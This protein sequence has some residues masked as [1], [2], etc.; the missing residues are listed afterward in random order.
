MTLTDDVLDKIGGVQRN[1]LSAVLEPDH[2]LT[3]TEEPVVFHP[4]PYTDHDSLVNVLKNKNDVFKCLSVNIQSINSKIDQL[5]IYLNQLQIDNC[6]FDAICIQET[7]LTGGSSTDHLQIEGYTMINSPCSLTSHSGLAIYLKYNIDYERI[8][9]APSQSQSWEGQFIHVKFPGNKDL[10]LGNIYRPPRDLIA[11]YKAFIEEFDQISCLLSGELVIAG[12]YNI[13]LLQI[14]NREIVSD[15]FES[16]MNN[17][18]VP[19]ITYPTRFSRHRGTLID[20]F[21]CRLSDNFS[22]TTTG[23]LTYKLS[24]HQPYFICL[25]YLKLKKSTIRYIKINNQ[26]NNNIQKVKEYLKNSIILNE[27]TQ[28]SHS[29]PN[30]SYRILNEVI[31]EALQLHMPTKIVKFNK[32]KHKKN[33]WITPAILKSIKF[34]DKLYIKFKKSPLNSHLH[35]Q[36]ETNLSTY[37]KI[38]KKTIR[39]AK[40]SYYQNRFKSSQ[41]DIKKTWCTIKEI[42]NKGQGKSEFPSAV[43]VNNNVITDLDKIAQEFNRYFVNVGPELA[44]KISEH[45]ND[46]FEQYLNRPAETVLKFNPVN[47]QEIIKIIDSLKN[48]TSF[49]SDGISTVLLKKIKHEISKPL[50]AI[51]NQSITSGIFPT[52]LKTAKITPVY[53][54]DDPKLLTNYRPI[55]LL[56][57]ISKVFEKVLAQQIHK[58]FENNK[59]FYNN[60][61][62]FRA[63]HSTQHAALELTDRIITDMDKGHIPLNIFIDLSKAFDTIDHNILLYKLKYYG[64]RNNAYDLMESYL[65]DRQQF[66]NVD[67]K[68]SEKLFLSTG[69]PQGSVL[70]PLLFIIYINDMHLCSKKLSTISYADDTTLFLTLSTEN[71]QTSDT[72]LNNELSKFSKWLDLNKLSL[73]VAKTKYMLFSPPNKNITYPQLKINNRVIECVKEFDFLGVLLDANMKWHS[74][75]NKISKKISKAIGIIGRIKNYMPVNT[76]RI[77]YFALVNSH[78]DYGLL[79][80]GHCATKLEISQKKAVRIVSKRK[81]NAHSEPLLK[82]LNILKITDL[83]KLKLLK[84]YYKLCNNLLPQY[85]ATANLLIHQQSLHSHNTRGQTFL[86]PRI[87]H[88]FAENCVRHQLP[89][90]LNNADDLPAD[91]LTSVYTYSEYG[92]TSYLKRH[93]IDQYNNECTIINCRN[94]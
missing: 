55:S 92:Y 37:N 79:N 14:N 59:Y 76:L 51:I 49:G 17:S 48:K 20:N 2:D 62:G 23:I 53:K 7:W 52:D 83:Y 50:T 67:N 90:L 41:S 77:L 10:T 29:D 64:I 15:Y 19:K 3:D 74:H 9:I 40:I 68:Q 18:L 58:Y 11:N 85:F 25:D 42:I 61:Y 6:S 80:W 78:L 24:D 45:P 54:K 81:Y 89:S 31:N 63:K 70:G 87:Y 65:K 13:D 75:V 26:N 28:D 22:E 21:L 94:C 36:L 32:H 12:D 35:H 16:I 66:V 88:V 44:S 71:L 39:N 82:K 8:T 73:N 72:L 34:R 93:F 33:N 84:F 47:T 38:L 86:T 1:S 91:V 60:Q 43:E 27:I 30:I 57:S 5:R 4:S 46:N 56:N 69:V